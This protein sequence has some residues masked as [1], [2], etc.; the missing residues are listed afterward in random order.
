MTGSARA[1][2]VVPSFAKPAKLGQPLL[3]VMQAK[4]LKLGQPPAGKVRCH[5]GAVETRG[6][7][8]PEG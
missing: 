4:K 7:Q 2:S 5:T 6:Y 1:K 3:V 8:Q